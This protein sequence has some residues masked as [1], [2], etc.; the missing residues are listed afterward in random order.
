MASPQEF[1]VAHK[2]FHTQIEPS[3]ILGIG[4]IFL[5]CVVLAQNLFMFDHGIVLTDDYAATN[6][7]VFDA[8]SLRQAYGTP[9]WNN[10][11]HPGPVIM[12]WRALFEAVFKVIGIEVANAATTLMAHLALI[13]VVGI[14]VFAAARRLPGANRQA[15]FALTSI[16]FAFWL[17]KPVFINSWWEPVEATLVFAWFLAAAAVA[18]YGSF[19]YLLIAVVLGS[20][21][22]Q[23]GISHC[24]PVF[25]VLALVLAYGFRGFFMG[26]RRQGC[27]RIV[28]LWIVGMIAAA[29]FLFDILFGR[30]ELIT[31]YINYS[32]STSS[33]ERPSFEKVLGVL[34]ENLSM[35]RELLIVLLL[36]F[37]GILIARARAGIELKPIERFWGY[38]LLLMSMVSAGTAFLFYKTASNNSYTPAHVSVFVYSC[39]AL[40]AGL[41]I[42]WAARFTGVR[43]ER[44]L[45]VAISISPLV[46]LGLLV[47]RA[48]PAAYA[49]PQSA[50]GIFISPVMHEMMA[51]VR[52]ATREGGAKT[53][54][55][56]VVFPLPGYAAT[57][58][59]REYPWRVAVGLMNMM[60]RSAV[61]YCV[62]NP[63]REEYRYG[64]EIMRLFGKTAQC[65]DDGVQSVT[66][67]CEGGKLV[68]ET[69]ERR[70]EIAACQTSA[71]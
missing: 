62:P 22:V 60:R 38:R 46:V 44:G 57:D 49:R 54:G 70:Y 33:M 16:L 30:R 2:A 52:K 1:R 9:S 45:L 31:K 12:Y 13:N 39:E 28:V 17:A 24:Y 6:I 25:V 67:K 65:A 23:L 47:V 4:L 21:C 7:G 26:S 29:P 15:A 63:P 48:G 59:E 55:V 8:L 10:Y 11:Y 58:D 53:I 35:P 43:F 64:Y 66:F 3:W 68:G 18:S 20:I 56:N 34:G 19:A 5:N 37:L 51:D 27:I 42:C 32:A 40:I 69:S 71:P 36:C 61:P 50:G 14:G 41:L